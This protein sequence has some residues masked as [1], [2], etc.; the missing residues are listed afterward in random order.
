MEKIIAKEELPNFAEFYVVDRMELIKSNHK[1][2]LCDKSHLM[3]YK[4]TFLFNGKFKGRIYEC[5]NC[6]NSKKPTVYAAINKPSESLK[7]FLPL[8]M[9]VE[10]VN[11]Y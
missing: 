2:I 7:P 10:R 4:S 9:V 11:Y 3:T 1:C 8:E 6:F 5:K